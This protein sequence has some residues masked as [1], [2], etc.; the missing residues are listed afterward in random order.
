MTQ[1]SVVYRPS[2]FSIPIQSPGPI[3]CD[4]V[5][6]VHSKLRSDVG[7]QVQLNSQERNPKKIV[8]C[9]IRQVNLYY[10]IRQILNHLP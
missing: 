3:D 2:V 10:A 8:A 9:I 1:T 5:G 4:S 6:D 7:I